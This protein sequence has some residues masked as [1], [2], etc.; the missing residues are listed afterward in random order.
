MIAAA[1]AVDLGRLAAEKRDDQKIADLAAMDASRDPA[2][3][4]CLAKISAS[5][6]IGPPCTSSPVTA[7]RNNFPTS[8]G[9][10]VTG[11]EGVLVPS[12]GGNTCQ[13]QAGAG[14]VCVTVTSPFKTAFGVVNGPGSVTARAMAGPRNPASF[15]LGSGVASID[16]NRSTLLNSTIGQMLCSPVCATGN[17]GLSLANW[18]GLASGRLSLTALQT[19]LASAGFSVGSVSQLMS[20]SMTL[21]QLYTATASALTTGGDSADATIFSA[22]ALKATSTTQITLGQLI[23]VQQGAD[24]AALGTSINLLQLVT[25]TAEI[26]N[27]SHAIDVSNVGITV[28]DVTSTRVQMT[29]TEPPVIFVGFYGDVGV[30]TAQVNVTVTPT[31]NVVSIPLVATITGSLPIVISGGRATGTLAAEPTCPSSGSKSFKVAVAT[32]AATVTQNSSLNVT[33]VTAITGVLTTTGNVAVAPN[34]GTSPA[35]VEQGTTPQ[36]FLPATWHFGGTSLGLNTA[37]TATG[38][39]SLAAVL[40]TLITTV[41]TVVG[42]V[43]SAIIEPL[44]QALGLDVGNAD[45]K[46]LSVLCG[47]PSLLG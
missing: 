26:A 7:N 32:Q 16:A 44:L 2:N 30:T 12:G 29:V 42:N 27:G 17:A 5:G 38:S 4:D 39:L 34:S 18:Q 13:A 46:P 15:S 1:L 45:V 14:K 35:F 10:S 47:Q 22:L 41:Q 25:G 8:A 24:K 6:Q 40:S 20:A 43:D 37:L 19:S 23:H 3:A 28:G 36:S 11:I 31:L 21:A 9:Y 33:L